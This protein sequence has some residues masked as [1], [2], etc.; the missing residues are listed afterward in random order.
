MRTLHLLLLFI[1]SVSLGARAAQLTDPAVA[2]QLGITVP[3][4]HQLRDQYGLSNDVL[5]A[6]RPD[7]LQILLSDAA[8]PGFDRHAEEQKFQMLKMMDEHGHIPPDGLIHA[9]EQRGRHIKTDQGD[10]DLTPAPPDTSTNQPSFGTA[11]PLV[12]GILNSNWT[13][14][15]PGN[16][17]GRVRAILPHPTATNT[18]WCGGVDGGVWKTTNGAVSWFP[19]NDFMANLAVACLTMDPTNANVIYAGTGEGTYNIDAVRGAGIFKSIDG[20]TNWIQLS[21]TANSSFQYV[22]RLSID[23]NNS[24]I[25]LAATRSGVWRSTNGGTNWTQRL[26]TEVLCIA[27]HPT[28]STQAI[29]SGYVGRTYYSTDGGQSWTAATG[30][31]S[32]SG[33]GGRVELAY[34]RSSP[35]LVFASVDNSSGQVYRSV[36][37]GHTYTLSNSGN[38]YLS[39]QG[40]YDNVVWADPVNTNVV[41][42]GGTDIWRST[43][44]GFTFTDIGGYSGSIHPDQHAIVATPFYNGSTIRTLYI[45]N[46]GGVW[47]ANDAYTA[48]SGSGWANL[49]HNLGITQF[50]GAAGNSNSLVIVGGT[51]DNGTLRY[52]TGGGPQGWTSMFGG[53]GGQCA[54][55]PLNS[56]YFYGEYV[57]LQI[58]RSINGGVSSSYIYSGITDAGTGNANFIAPFILDPNN[59][60]TMLAGGSSLWRSTNVK[61]GT[62][63][64]TAIKASIG[65]P[66]SAIAVA[67]GNSD[68]IWVGHNNGA[69]YMTTNGTA[70]SPTW[71]QRNTGLPGRYCGSLA[72][73]RTP[74]RVYATFTGYNSGNVWQT[75]NSG[76]TWSSITANLPAAPMNSIVISPNDTNTLYVG[77]EVGVYG[78]INNGGSWSTGNDG[79]ANVAVDQLF[80]WGTKLVAVT[81]GRGIYTTVPLVGPPGLL[82]ASYQL[83]DANTNGSVDANECSQVNLL[84]QNTNGVVATNVSAVLSSPTPGITIMQGASAYP[85]ISQGTTV[86]N[87]TPFQIS[88][89]SALACGSTVTL[90]LAVSANG[91]TNLLTYSLPS[92]GNYTI[93]VNTGVSIIPGTTDTGNHGQNLTTPITLPFPFTYYGRSFTNATLSSA[94][95]LYFVGGNFSAGGVC[96]PVGGFNNAIFP[97]WDNLRTDTNGGGIYTAISG[98]APNRI[99]AIEWLASMV[100]SGAALDFE[101]LLYEGQQRF[102]IVYGALGDP[103]A[104][105]TVG[106]QRDTGV[107]YTNYECSA[108]G[109]SAGLQLVCQ[110]QCGAGGGQCAPVANFTASPTSGSAPLTVFF[111]NLSLA[112]SSYAWDFGDGNTNSASNPT[113]TYASAGTYSV[114]L[115]VTG[116]GGSAALTQTNY[117][118]VTNAPPSIFGQ[119]PDQTV[120]RGL[121]VTFNVGASGTPPLSYQWRVGGAPITDATNSSYGILN[122]QCADAGGYDV[123]ITNIAGSITSRVAL[124]TVE[125]PP[126]ILVEPA[127]SVIVVLNHSWS[128]SI[129][130]SNDCGDGLSYQWSLQGTNLAGATTS[131]YARAN[132]QLSD[133]GSYQVLV[134]NVAGSATSTVALVTVLVPPNVATAP[135]SQSVPVGSNATFTVSATGTAPLNYQWRFAG[136]PIAGATGTQ[137]TRTNA[138]CADT[139]GFDVVITNIAGSVT[140]ALATLTVVTPPAIIAEPATNITVVLN[141]PWSLSVTA[142]ND[143]GNGLTYQWSLQGTN[144]AGATSNVFARANA[145]L[146]DAG[147]YQVVVTN[148]AGSA[149]STVSLVTVLTPPIVVAPPAPQIVPVGSNATFTVSATG[150]TPL[151][152]QW[153]FAGT[154]ITGANGPVYTRTDAQCADTGGF[155]VVVTNLAGSVTSV[156]GT[157]TVVAPPV[158][159]SEPTNLTVVAGQSA[160][161]YSTA[162]NDCGGGLQYQ[163]LR[164]GTNLAN[165][166][167]SNF[168]I[169]SAQLSDAAGYWLVVTNLAGS[170]TSSVATLTVLTPAQLVAS[171]AV[172]DFGVIV[173]GTTAQASIVVSNAGGA[174]LN[175]TAAIGGGPFVLVGAAGGP[176]L[177][178]GFGSTNLAIDFSPLVS[179]SY[180]NTVVFTSN[181]GSA[182]NTL[183]GSAVDTFAPTILSPNISGTNF[184]FSFQ[185]IAGRTYLVQYKDDLETTGWQLLETIPGDGTLKTVITT[186]A[187]P[188]QRFYRLK[189]Q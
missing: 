102:D 25:I 174:Q 54:S 29:A 105:A 13:W 183:L 175:G 120:A 107:A 15:G 35:N 57:D 92:A 181:G 82:A 158:L 94:G 163:W 127:P 111:N 122:P 80:W 10:S 117:I 157:L 1:L 46:D 77:S 176:W 51:Q 28:D 170:A 69:I 187:S 53:D 97:F 87:V 26:S 133:A 134:T 49:N 86:T 185:S 81:H 31:P 118:V 125:T 22:S 39:S 3:Q 177:V 149:T 4:L 79:P 27:F 186:Y 188:M 65:S 19:L 64:W 121:S 44:G 32:S 98:T 171:P 37:G 70:A 137:Y 180:S 104:T 99:F 66:I 33:L 164:A 18:L 123:V 154:P 89:S 16:I 2:Q 40:W 138:Q 169:P 9:L 153:R 8:R 47:R 60:N 116:T 58:H 41:L 113:N 17:G 132:A 112:A 189:V 75:S 178:P 84:I 136:A 21:S 156:V 124:L 151:S 146:S 20:G 110:M 24:Q 152:Y 165:A 109:L 150:S 173:T 108:G 140:S 143:C 72:V 83:Y 182:T 172:L 7:Q 168:V 23:P 159:V 52:T 142:T 96:L 135:A 38:N 148:L 63:T 131:V 101:V 50:Y 6:I 184:T 179:G 73:S 161:F 144:V 130:A 78:T 126:N 62:P 91:G 106:F 74:G 155:D 167:N 14:L 141:H 160:A 166:T 42:V 129:T 162:T 93:T 43:D 34:S 76:L 55:D 147:S 61:A 100:S 68:I 88:S 12:A 48:S 5:L 95:N 45:G 71:T 56:S 119:P 145:Q 67:S 128:L 11:G 85:N 103:G 59:P 30:V 115:A 139:G 114:S 90:T 36:D